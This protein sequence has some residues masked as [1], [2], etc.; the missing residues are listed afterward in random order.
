[1]STRP[2]LSHHL[3]RVLAV[4]DE[5]G[6][7]D[8]YREILQAEVAAPR[9]AALSDMRA[10]L[11]GTGKAVSPAATREAVDLVCCSGAEEAVEA[12]RLANEEGRP[13]ALVLLDMRMPPGPDGLW[14][15]TRIRAMDP[16]IDLI[17]VTA[18]SDIDPE[19][20]TQRV[21]PAGSL[22]YLQKP[23]HAHE[24]RQLVSA[25]GRRRQAED[26]IRRLAYFDEVT[27]LPN[28]AFF[29]ERLSQTLEIARRHCW[30]MA[31]LFLD[32]DNFK[33][34]NDT[35]GHSIGDILLAEVAK[36]LITSLRSSDAIVHGH[37]GD[38]GEQVARLGGDEFTVLL[39]EVS[40]AEGAGV[41]A[42]RLLDVLAQPLLLAGHE[43]TVTASIGIA[44]YPNDGQDVETL[45]KSADMAMYFAK[46]KGRSNFQ[47]YTEA[48]NSAALKRLTMENALRRALERGELSVHYQPQVDIAT[49]GIAGVEALARWNSTELGLVSPAEFIP[50]AE[51]TGLI[52]PIGDWI[53]RTACAQC[54]A[55]RDEG[56]PLLRVAVNISVRQFAQDGFTAQIAAILAETGLDAGG[57]E[58]EITESLLMKDGESALVTLR[59]LKQLGVQLAIDDFG[60]G[61]SSLSYL[62]QFPIDRL[63]IDRSFV[64]GVN[65]NAQDRAITAAV[66]A[67]AD[68]MDLKVTAEGVETESQ[69]VFLGDRRCAEAQ[70][71]FLSKPLPPMAARDYLRQKLSDAV[72]RGP[73]ALEL[74]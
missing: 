18:Y 57:L 54:K 46:R 28:R 6:I 9:N 44:V 69:L 25:L 11:F 29:M 31:L 68:S 40:A 43:I 48:M 5:P 15:A 38:D 26:R 56:I 71:F 19:E 20:I 39:S 14:A 36:R 72:D 7:R 1:M 55:W 8:A 61:Y 34:I 13:F 17:I 42:A 32:L 65:M 74:E 27:G 62:K 41:A 16:R 67:L 33:R 50:L 12:V 63:K 60:T 21:P 3:I 23:F 59:E 10:R 53:L 70:G 73:G 47:F 30:S 64:G 22:F 66:I 52:L 49:G 24:V 4:D 58:L 51:E 45:L 35:L 37:A 2:P